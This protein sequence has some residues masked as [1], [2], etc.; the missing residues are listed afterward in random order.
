MKRISMMAVALLVV[1]AGSVSAQSPASKAYAVLDQA[2]ATYQDVHSLRA[3]FTQELTNPLLGTHTASAGTLFQREPD[4]FLMRFSKPAGDRIVSDGRY[5]WIYYP[6]VD[7]KQVIRSPAD[8]SGRP[9]VDLQAQFIGNPEQRFNATYD[10]TATLQGRKTDVLT[11]VPR[12][13]AGYTSMKVWIDAQDH[14]VRQFEITGTQGLV[15][16]I[17][18]RDIVVNLTLPDSLFQFT[19]PAGAHVI[20][21]G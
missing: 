6:S 3:E 20:D 16:H 10:G 15:R 1:A 19:P 9:G 4:G 12:T 8:V 14:L 21:R 11:L 13:A 18:L 5:F 17:E 7:A 2:V